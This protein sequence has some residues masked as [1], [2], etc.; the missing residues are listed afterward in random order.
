MKSAILGAKIGKRD[1]PALK[2]KMERIGE[3]AASR[4]WF[5]V[6][7]CCAAMRQLWPDER[8][9]ETSVSANIRNLSKFGWRVEGRWKD[10][11][12]RLYEYNVAPPLPA[13]AQPYVRG[14]QFSLL[15]GTR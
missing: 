12:I 4:Q 1:M 9:P 5:T 13:D 6:P 10:K 3:W 2:S 7:Q 8:W 15:E 11:A 14:H